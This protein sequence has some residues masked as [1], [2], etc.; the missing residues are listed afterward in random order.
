MRYR[1]AIAVHLL[2]LLTFAV[3]G[4]SGRTDVEAW[5]EGIE[6]YRTG[7]VTNALRVLRPLML[8]RSH[9]ARAAEVVSK[10]EFERGNREEAATAAQIAL[11]A[12]PKDAK[13][14]RNFT[15]A[16]D[17]LAE[18][19]ETR[20]TDE[21]LT[22]Y[23]GADPGAIMLMATRESRAIMES[24]AGYM[25]N[26]AV[27]TVALA[28]ELSNR[29]ER[30]VDM[31][32]PVKAAICQAVTN[33]EQAAT[34]V[35]Q[36]DQAREKTRRASRQI[37]DIAPEAYS[38]A[39]DVEHDCTRFLKMTILPP[40]AMSEDLLAQSNAWL[41]AA[42]I[43]GREWQRDALDYTRAFRAK[44][45]AWARAYEQQS[46]NDTNSVPFTADDQ[47]K[48]SAL[49]TELE[50]L[51]MESL[52]NNDVAAQEKSLD[53][54]RKI[55]ELL[56][57][58]SGQGGHT[59]E[60]QQPQDRQPQN[61]QGEGQ[62]SESDQ[63]RQ[64]EEPSANDADEKSGE[65]PQEPTEDEKEIEAILRKAQERSDEHEADKRARMRKAPLSPNE[66]DW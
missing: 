40:E 18:L 11:R 28:D 29:A 55:E 62:G 1:R 50:K 10:L 16:V 6:Y 15:R 48:I 65:E 8:T 26:D 17:G 42:A 19:R 12:N 37:A 30:L 36:V 56:P 32:I 33:E 52:E 46:Q 2:A 51:Q 66:R 24:V 22:A 4:A 45:P 54:I 14:N 43:N 39:S 63:D 60:G 38:S 61:G 53:T 3:E 57:K 27:R 34:I 31:W 41:K 23:Q 58:Q 59:P 64:P 7:D 20:R 21:A 5:N 47:A 44:F 25:T 35:M 9:G 13:A 49:A